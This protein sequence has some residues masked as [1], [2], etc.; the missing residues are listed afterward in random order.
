[1]L[2]DNKYPYDVILTPMGYDN[3]AALYPGQQGKAIEDAWTLIQQSNNLGEYGPAKNKK[4]ATLELTRPMIFWNPTYALPMIGNPSGID[5]DKDDPT[6]LPPAAKNRG[7]GMYAYV[8]PKKVMNKY[9][10]KRVVVMTKTDLPPWI[11][12]WHEIGHIYQAYK[13][14]GNPRNFP[15]TYSAQQS[16]LE[17]DN[18]AQ[19]E[20]P[21][22][23]E[24]KIPKRPR[25]KHT[26]SALPFFDAIRSHMALENPKMFYV[27]ASDVERKR[28]EEELQRTAIK[29]HASPETVP[30]L[31][32][33]VL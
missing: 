7:K 1:L 26:I 29:D 4:A 33:N 13:D 23:D 16:A 18:L 9:T 14:N 5:P 12:L 25:Y 28:L 17:K 32:F 11:V 8:G 22:C 21:L 31:H 24:A 2:K 10:S 27:A 20:H 3:G 6:I 15:D 30:G 19:I